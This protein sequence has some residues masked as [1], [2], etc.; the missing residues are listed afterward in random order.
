MINPDFVAISKG[1]FIEASKVDKRKRFR[2]VENKNVKI[3]WS[4]SLRS[5]D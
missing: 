2:P 1:Y 3:R 4:I 5:C